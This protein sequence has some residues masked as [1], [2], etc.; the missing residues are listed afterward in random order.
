MAHSFFKG[1]FLICVFVLSDN[2]RKWCYCEKPNNNKVNDGCRESYGQESLFLFLI[3]VLETGERK[4]CPV[5]SPFMRVVVNPLKKVCSLSHVISASCVCVYFS[6]P[7]SWPTWWVRASTSRLQTCCLIASSSCRQL[8]F[9]PGWGLC[10]ATLTNQ[11]D[12]FWRSLLFP[13]H[14]AVAVKR[15]SHSEN[16]CLWLYY[17]RAAIGA[18]ASRELVFCSMCCQE[19]RWVWFHTSCS[20]AA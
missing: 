14:A 13:C 19:S 16:G 18:V 6:M 1:I 10:H 3:M 8:L 9:L 7:T 2:Y 4:F 11:W 20:V 15:L 5:V 12:R 17:T